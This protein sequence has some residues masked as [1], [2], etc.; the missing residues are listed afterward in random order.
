MIEINLLPGYL[1]TLPEEQKLKA[2]STARL[3]KI[4]IIVFCALV[5]FFGVVY[6]TV[7][8]M[9][10]GYYNNKYSAVHQQWLAIKGEYAPIKKML[11]KEKE[12]Y[13]NE[14]ALKK[15]D[16]QRYAW[17]M[18]L[19][20]ISDATPWNVHLTSIKSASFNEMVSEL[21]ITMVGGRKQQTERRGMKARNVLIVD[22]NYKS[23]DKNDKTIE[24]FIANLKASPRFENIFRK[25]D[26]MSFESGK[27]DFKNFSIRCWFRD[28]YSRTVK[29]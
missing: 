15:K 10:S 2:L 12:F 19:N 17:S 16:A 25:V 21:I 11:D 6:V 4:L 27:N 22:G 14:T 9:P 18:I 29:K 3:K 24:T 13:S 5:C 7:V 28:K 26:L 23:L 20:T 1:R 8:L